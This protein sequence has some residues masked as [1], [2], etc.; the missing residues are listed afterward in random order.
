MIT[1]QHILDLA[2]AHLKTTDKF[3]VF[4]TIK[5]TNRI[6]LFIDGDSGVTIDDC[7]KLSRHIESSLDRE[8]EDF[9]LQVSSAGADQPLL[10]PRQYHKHVGR[11][12]KVKTRDGA[13]FVGKLQ[14]V[15]EDRFEL[16][17]PAIKKEKKPETTV[18]IEFE[19]VQETKIELSFKQP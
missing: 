12:L 13:L 2:N 17:L 6:L 19:N 4:L 18:D 16:L 1:Q 14:S 10:L 9:E 8:K 7:V 5:P 11:T 3:V 15:G